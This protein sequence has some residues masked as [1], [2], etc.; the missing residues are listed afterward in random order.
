MAGQSALGKSER[1][2]WLRF[3]DRRALLK[4]LLLPENAKGLILRVAET[5]AGR[6]TAA[7]AEAFGFTAM[8]NPGLYRMVFPDGRVPFSARTLAEALGGELFALDRSDLL[9]SAWTMDFTAV[10]REARADEPDPASMVSVGLNLRGEDVVRD[11]RGRFFRR[12]SPDGGPARFISEANETQHTLFLRAARPEDL[13]AIAAGV[14]MMAT[15]G[16]VHRDDISRVLDAALEPGPH[17]RLAMDRDEAARMLRAQTLRQVA[18]RAIEGGTSRE[19]FLQ[20]LR[21]SGA[22]GAALSEPS[23]PEGFSPSPALLAFLRRAVAGEDGVDFRGHPDLA[24]GLPRMRRSDARLQVHDFDAVAE[25][26]RSTYGQNL[27]ARRPASGRS[28]LILPGRAEGETFERL[29][30]DVGLAYAIEAV[31]EVSPLVADGL[32]DGQHRTMIFVGERRPEPLEALP[33]AA[34]RV[35]SV[36][37]SDDLL[38]FEREIGRSRNRI[39]D[40]HAGIEEEQRPDRDARVE[41]IR[42]RPYQPLSRIGDPFTMIPLALEGATSRAL[43]RVHRDFEQRGGVDAV[44]AASLGLGIG[45]L[46]QTLTAEQ[47]DAVGMSIH[48]RDRARGF[49]LADQTGVGKGRSLAAM[50]RAFLRRDP[51]NK[52]LYFTESPSINVPDVCRDLK[53]VGAMPEVRLGFLTT[54]SSWIDRSEDP[55]TGQEIAT[56][57]KSL[58]GATQEAIFGSGVWPQAYNCLL[59]TYSR[60]NSGPENIR[61]QWLLNAGDEHTLVILDEAHN[62]LNRQ[63]NMGRNVRGLIERVGPENVIFGTATPARNPS[64]MDL[65]RPLLPRTDLVALDSLLDDVAAGGEVAQEAVATMMAEDGVMLRRDHDLSTVEFRVDLPSDERMLRYQAIMDQFSP[66]VEQMVD[67]SIQIGEVVGNRRD[68]DYRNAIQRGMAPEAA[69]ALTNGLSQY[70]LAIGGPLAMLSR[71]VMN[72]V[73]VDQVADVAL[74]TIREG[75]KPLITFHSTNSSL[76]TDSVRGEDGRISEDRLEQVTGLTLSDQIRRIHDGIYRVRFGGEQ[77]DARANFPQIQA[78]HDQIEAMIATLPAD[79]PV[80]PIDALIERL[81]ANDVRVGE[82]SGRTLCYRGDR[83]QRRN[84][85][86][87]KAVIDDFNR[88][89]LDVLVYNSAGATGG[90]YH[91]APEFQ[92]QRGRTLIEFETP[93]DIIKYIQAQGRGN[94]YGQ[95][96]NPIVHSVMTGLTPEM[97]ILQQRNR[98]LRALGASVDGNRSHPLLLDDIPDLLN[99]VGDE[100]T[101][102]VLTE[103]PALARRLGFPELAEALDRDYERVRQ[104]REVDDTGSGVAKSGMESL[105]NKVLVRSIS[106]PA[107]EQDDLIQRIRLEFDALIE[108][109]ESRNANPLRPREIEGTITIRGTSLF[110]GFERADGDLDSS[111]FTAPLYLSTGIHEFNA[112]AF[113]AER[114]I[115]EVE[116]AQR[117]HGVEGFAPYAARI[118]QNL[119]IL[120]RRHLPEGIDME[121][122]LQNPAAVGGRFMVR[123]TD[124]TDMAWLLENLR[125]GV[126][127]RFPTVMDPEARE[128]RTIIGVTPPRDNSMLTMGA[129]FKITTISPGQAKPERISV[130]RILFADREKIFFRPGLSEGYNEA[131]LEEFSREA[132]LTRRA[133]RQ[134]LHGNTLQA[135]S[136]A[137]KNRLGTIALYRDAEGRMQRG[138]VVNPTKTDLDLLPVAIPSE[139][140]ALELAFRFLNNQDGRRSDM[141]KIWGGMD[142]GLGP[143]SRDGADII[144]GI[145]RKSCIIDIIPFRRSSEAWFR[146]R[147]E[148]HERLWGGPMP[149]EAPAFLRRM[150]GENHRH[151]VKIFFDREPEGR[152]R[153]LDILSALRDVPMMTDGLHRAQVND[154]TAILERLQNGATRH[155]DVPVEAVAAP[156]APTEAQATHPGPGPAPVTAAALPAPRPVGPGPE[157]AA[158]PVGVAPPDLPDFD[159]LDAVPF[160]P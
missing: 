112:D 83:I 1:V 37:T 130:S 103:N 49:L 11:A 6:E 14:V 57:T 24:L 147:P 90:S 39:R 50:A 88:G 44:V 102:N 65:Y 33:Q 29:R 54:G 10:R 66:I 133:P 157:L 155:F 159:D 132:N 60:F 30:S 145:T 126:E 25:T 150:P 123:H 104:S 160:Q 113:N 119:P 75:R 38:V 101:H 143:G 5:D 153:V 135:I 98:K 22:L 128:R 48:A 41:N 85:G 36:L 99:A 20:S 27:L 70:S 96:V 127:L 64:G 131:H 63:S 117:L 76:L 77:I 121:D 3:P 73:K 91:A 151:L 134:I 124:L 51:R 17:G 152:Q 62:A 40:F 97:R 4:R 108:E 118:T 35:L 116:R 58:P 69:R 55:A 53:A 32:Q 141:L 2:A 122:A 142:P 56:E 79:L 21:L 46:G 52:V 140:I 28:I 100:A 80:S 95:V 59:T 149:A 136:V 138:I 16:T 12:V 34:M 8:R 106:L 9:S 137:R 110:G 114:L 144:I 31:A 154:I 23:G 13:D 19:A 15:R 105:A 94:R 81:E 18:S 93:V 61:S 120:L 86:N 68:A 82:I 45:D 156:E 43:Q 115:L 72:A 26:A 67:A 74:Q 111:S 129:A 71:M 148:L 78:L 125:P 87:R 92:D 47:V 158:A 7:A 89:D 109:L 42:Q 107:R 84:A 139:R 146:E